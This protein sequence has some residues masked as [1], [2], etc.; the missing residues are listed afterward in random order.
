MS[1]K[2]RFNLPGLAQYIIQRGNNQ[3]PC[4]YSLD[5]YQKYLSILA[6]VSRLIG[7]PS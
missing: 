7:C 1:R 5:D 2:P 3:E 4:F 6:E